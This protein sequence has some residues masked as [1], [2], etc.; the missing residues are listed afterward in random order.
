MTLIHILKDNWGIIAASIGWI[1]WFID[2]ML[3]FAARRRVSLSL[4]FEDGALHIIN[5]GQEGL[6]LGTLGIE[7]VDIRMKADIAKRESLFRGLGYTLM[8]NEKKVLLK[9][10]RNLVQAVERINR[11]YDD[12]MRQWEP[13]KIFPAFCGINLH[14]RYKKISGKIEKHIRFSRCI[15]GHTQIG[16]GIHYG[17]YYH[18]KNAP[19]YIK[20]YRKLGK[21]ISCIFH[22]IKTFRYLRKKKVLQSTLD[23]DGVFL[24]LAQKTLTEEEAKQRL[25]KILRRVTKNYEDTFTRIWHDYAQQRVDS[26]ADAT[27][28]SP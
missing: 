11:I 14:L 6:E 22:P 27:C 24:G 25:K 23:I 9:I 8:P 7:L 3:R 12:Q 10:N 16:W 20:A 19:I 21:L 2:R 17:P 18:E 1:G 5:N 13:D 15:S 26:S 28:E 4:S